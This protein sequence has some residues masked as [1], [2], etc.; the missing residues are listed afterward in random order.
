MDFG[1]QAV[2]VANQTLIYRLRAQAQSRL[3]AAYMLFY[4]AGSASGGIASTLAYD[5]AGWIGVC[6]LGACAALMA[7]VLW[8]ATLNG[9]LRSE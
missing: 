6:L 8:V 1:L 9:T 3:T 5:R 2:H 4:S 7:I